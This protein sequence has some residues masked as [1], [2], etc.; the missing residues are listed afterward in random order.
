[1][2]NKQE[3]KKSIRKVEPKCY[4]IINAKNQILKRKMI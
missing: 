4:E 2:P 1:L 3:E